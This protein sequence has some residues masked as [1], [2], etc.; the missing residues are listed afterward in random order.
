MMNSVRVEA[1]DIP[2][3]NPITPQDCDPLLS[4]VKDEEEGIQ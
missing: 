4:S 1:R 2:E 3:H